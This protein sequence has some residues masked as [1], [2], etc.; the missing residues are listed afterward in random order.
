MFEI[1]YMYTFWKWKSDIIDDAL[2]ILI[3]NL[4][5]ESNHHGLKSLFPHFLI[6]KLSHLLHKN[7][8]ELYQLGDNQNVVQSKN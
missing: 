1:C 5:S 2:W 4:L 6:K 3:S 8:L 7:K